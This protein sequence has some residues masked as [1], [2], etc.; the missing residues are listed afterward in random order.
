MRGEKVDQL[1]TLIA[2]QKAVIEAERTKRTQV[3]K[4]RAAAIRRGVD[5]RR[6][7]DNSCQL[8]L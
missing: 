8:N 3:H 7:L 6:A 2:K 5:H 1:A 4:Q